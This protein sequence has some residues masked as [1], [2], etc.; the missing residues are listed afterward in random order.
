MRMQANKNSV[1]RRLCFHSRSSACCCESDVAFCS[2]LLVINT[3]RSCRQHDAI[4]RQLIYPATTMEKGEGR[5]RSGSTIWWHASS[6]SSCGVEDS[7]KS[8]DIEVGHRR[9]CFRSTKL[10]RAALQGT[11]LHVCASPSHGYMAF[12]FPDPA[13][14][15]CLRGKSASLPPSSLTPHTSHIWGKPTRLPFR[16]AGPTAKRSPILRR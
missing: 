8:G 3:K 10:Y 12:I 6:E 11:T 9:P 4:Q 16:H 13:T 2:A 14:R 1:V 7:R 15:V 5:V